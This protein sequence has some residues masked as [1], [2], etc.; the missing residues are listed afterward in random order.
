M[1]PR[2]PSSTKGT[3]MNSLF[4]TFLDYAL[5]VVIACLLAW[6]LAVALV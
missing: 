5:A 4:E 2:N 6:F 3:A 1:A